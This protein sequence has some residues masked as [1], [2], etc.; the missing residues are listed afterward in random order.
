VITQRVAVR[1]IAW[2]AIPALCKS[3]VI[4]N[5]FNATFGVMRRKF[6]AL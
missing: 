5:S 1:R 4:G 6:L 2:L 3:E